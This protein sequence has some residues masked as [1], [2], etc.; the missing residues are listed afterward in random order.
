MSLKFEPVSLP[1][2]WDW[3]KMGKEFIGRVY[4]SHT[5]T[6]TR[7]LSISLSPTHA[8]SLSL[9]LSL[10]L[11]LSHTH[12]LSLSHTHYLSLSHTHTRGQVWDWDK[13]GKEFIGRVEVSLYDILE[14]E[15]LL[16]LYYSRA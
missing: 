7:C 4:L 9:S 10:P 5:Q 14:D 6:H 1:Q 16:L 15:V 11:S 12:T 3:D 8:L 13:M 2:V